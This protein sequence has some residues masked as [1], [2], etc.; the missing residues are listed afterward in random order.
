M[1]RRLTVGYDGAADP[2]RRLMMA[3]QHDDAIWCAF[4][5][6]RPTTTKRNIIQLG[7]V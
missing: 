6:K 2:P 5:N 1:A 3:R 4:Y 7:L